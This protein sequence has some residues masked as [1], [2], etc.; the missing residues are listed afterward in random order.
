MAL[1]AAAEGAATEETEDVIPRVEGE[2]I[3]DEDRPFHRCA[4]RRE[5]AP[6]GHPPTPRFPT[7]T[8]TSRAAR[9]APESNR[10]KTFRE[11][12]PSEKKTFRLTARLASSPGRV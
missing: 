4:P 6:S 12:V 5:E 11:N 9:R 8:R 7:D 3:W 2:F 10:S 1:K